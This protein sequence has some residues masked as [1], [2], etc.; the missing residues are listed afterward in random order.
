MTVRNKV[1]LF[2]IL[3]LYIILPIIIFYNETLFKY[4]FY[5]LTI[6]GTLIYIGLRISKVTNK[7]LGI[8]KT[9]ILNS[10]KRNI[11][12]IIIFIIIIIIFKLFSLAKYTPNETIFFYLFYIFISCPLQ[13]FLYRGVFGCFENNIIKNKYI[14][15][16]LSS[17]CYSFVHIIYHDLLTIVL[18]FIFGIFLYLLYRRDYNLFGVSVSHIVLGILTIYLGIV[19]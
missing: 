16:F 15:I 4:K 17:F 11:P 14:I 1:L 6:V 5:I 7:E 12:I 9:N 8:K 13:E 10:L 3:A 2:L 19:N 18:T